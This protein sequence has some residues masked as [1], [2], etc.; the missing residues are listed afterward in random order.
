MLITFFFPLNLMNIQVSPSHFKTSTLGVHAAHVKNV[1]IMSNSESQIT[2]PDLQIWQLGQDSLL[3][4]YPVLSFSSSPSEALILQTHLASQSFHL[5]EA[6]LISEDPAQ[7]DKQP[8]CHNRIF[9]TSFSI[10]AA[11][12][13]IDAQLPMKAMRQRC[14]GKQLSTQITIKTNPSFS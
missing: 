13:Q 3:L 5:H 9:P 1:W 2:L 8:A 6:F 14:L 12:T 7:E 4:L 10:S 11:K